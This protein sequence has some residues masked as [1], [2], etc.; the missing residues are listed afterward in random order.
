MVYSTTSSYTGV[1]RCLIY[2]SISLTLSFVVNIPTFL[3][4]EH[5]SDCWD[6]SAC[7]CGI[8]K[9]STV[10][11]TL[12]RNNNIYNHIYTSW[13]CII[14]TGLDHSNQQSILH[15]PYRKGVPLLG[16]FCEGLLTRRAGRDVEAG[17]EVFM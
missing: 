10:R 4:T 6:F 5:V 16:Y 9:Y 3:E 8:K 17:R 11:S 2:I 12:L 7:N 14:F 1:F 13:T 15:K